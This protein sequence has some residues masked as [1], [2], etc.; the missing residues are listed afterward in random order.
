VHLVDGRGFA[1]RHIRPGAG[2]GAA[3]VDVLGTAL[4]FEWLPMS[5]LPTSPDLVEGS[6]TRRLG[7]AGE[8]T[9]RFPNATSSKGLWREKFSEAGAREWIE[10]YR[11]GVLEFCGVIQRVEI[12]RSTV[13]V[14][15]GDGLE[16]LKRAYERDR[17]WHHAPADVMDHYTQVWTTELHEDWS[18]TSAW[19][20]TGAGTLTALDGQ[21]VMTASSVGTYTQANFPIADIDGDWEIETGIQVMTDPWGLGVY[22]SIAITTTGSVN[23]IEIRNRQPGGTSRYGITTPDPSLGAANVAATIA[24]DTNSWGLHHVIRIRR[25]GRWLM[26]WVDDRL[27][28]AVETGAGSL[29]TSIELSLLWF[30]PAQGASPQNPNPANTCTATF[31]P[32]T[33]RRLTPFLR[34]GTARGD[35]VLPGDYPTGGLRGRYHNLG[36]NSGFGTVLERRIRSLTPVSEPYGQRLDETI[37]TTTDLFLPLKPGAADDWFGVRWTGSIWLPLTKGP[38]EVRLYNTDDAGRLWVRD[39]RWGKQIA[40]GWYALGTTQGT[41]TGDADGWYPIIV[42]MVEDAGVYAITLQV[43]AAAGWTDPGGTVIPANTWTTVPATSLSPLGCHEARIQGQSHFQ[44]VQDAAS[45]AGY[46]LLLEP[47]SLESGEFPGRLIPRLRV[48]RDTDVV[49]EVDDT[50]AAEP[51]ME[52]VVT[53]DAAEQ[54]TR[55]I[56]AGAGTADGKGGQTMVEV[57]DHTT[58]ALFDLESWVDAGDASLPQLLEARANAEL[59][60]R[61]TPWEE[62]RGAPRALERLADT[63]PLTGALAAMR[64][65]PGDGLRVSVPDIGVLDRECR[66]LTQ[67][68]RQ[69]AA[70]GSTATQV[71]WRQRPRSAAASLRRLALTQALGQRSYQSQYE[72]LTSNYVSTV[73]AA[74]AMTDYAILPLQ[75]QDRVVRAVVRVSLNPGGGT[76]GAEVNGILR[77]TDLGGGW[78]TVPLEIDITAYATQASTSDNRLYVRLSRTGGTSAALQFQVIVAVLR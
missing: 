74:G 37:D 60:L 14:S 23:G 67:V 56:G 15:G 38:I 31:D 34:R 11:D 69:F 39:T 75:P 50:D 36:A 45:Q 77:T 61:N 7:D 71:A 41:L 4:G 51:I 21:A 33:F 58:G 76:L 65:R 44:I 48:G 26:G 53:R 18:D 63:W 22:G 46:Q 9:L 30:G 64:W 49:L 52:P 8:F 47:M 35:L 32:I 24:G 62:V 55:L 78:T 3:T 25:A 5:T 13:T 54:T 2:E 1:L 12:T 6:Y 16:L 59:A 73:V 40:D 27:A 66:Q 42:E 72:T 10:I 68:T 20:V 19:T 28:M 57:A 29:G 70:E 43:R 17:V